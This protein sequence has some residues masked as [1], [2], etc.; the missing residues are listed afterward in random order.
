MQLAREF[1]P[2][3]KIP[4]QLHPSPHNEGAFPLELP[5]VA[6]LRNFRHQST[7][8]SLS[9]TYLQPVSNLS[10]TLPRISRKFPPSLFWAVSCNQLLDSEIHIYSPPIQGR[11]NQQHPLPQSLPPHSISINQILFF[12][13]ANKFQDQAQGCFSQQ[14][15]T[16][17]FVKLTRSQSPQLL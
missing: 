2:I 13:I 7:T 5:C 11:T 6:S 16:E 17:Y 1:Y 3:V 15:V 10:P 9:P 4:G 14:T 8:S 12:N